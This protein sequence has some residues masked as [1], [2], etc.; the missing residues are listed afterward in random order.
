M[1]RSDGCLTLMQYNWGIY[2]RWIIVTLENLKGRPS[3]GAPT[4]VGSGEGKNWGKPST[5]KICGEAASNPWPSD[6]VRRLSPLHQACPSHPGKSAHIKC[7]RCL[8]HLVDVDMKWKMPSRHKKGCTRYRVKIMK[9]VQRIFPW[10]LQLFV[11]Q[12]ITSSLYHFY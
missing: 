8:E 9:L 7:P 10:K 5:R 11:L 6:S 2:Q 3:A 4:W 1:L 12:C